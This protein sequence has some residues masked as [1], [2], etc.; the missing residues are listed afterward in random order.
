MMA[1]YGFMEA[2][3]ITANFASGWV[4]LCPLRDHPIQ[5]E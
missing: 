1:V 2:L 4:I 5:N 3:F